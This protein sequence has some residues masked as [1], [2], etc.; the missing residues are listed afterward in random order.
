MN[1]CE[2]KAYLVLLFSFKER[3]TVFSSVVLLYSEFYKCS[4][5]IYKCSSLPVEVRINDSKTRLFKS[6]D[7]ALDFIINNIKVCNI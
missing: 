3:I 2:F 6:Y 7:E 1:I 4:L 5:V